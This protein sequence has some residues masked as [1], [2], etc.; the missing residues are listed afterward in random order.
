[1]GSIVTLTLL[2][3]SFTACSLV[4][5]AKSRYKIRLRAVIAQQKAMAVTL[6]A[7]KARLEATETRLEATEDKLEATMAKLQ[8]T[9]ADVS[10]RFKSG[11]SF[12]RWG[13]ESCPNN[14]NLVYTGVAGGKP[15]GQ[16]GSGT[17]PLCLTTTPQ[18]D[19]TKT[20]SNHGYVYGAKY[21]SIPGHSNHEVAPCSVCLAA[22]S[23]TIMVPATLACPSGW[24][25]QYTGHLVS[26]HK[27]HYATEYV[28][29]DGSSEVFSTNITNT[30]L[31]FYYVINMCGNLPCPPFIENRVLTCVVCSK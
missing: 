10:T 22:Q 19:D 27:T 5:C 18:Y 24:T 13:R 1:M 14:T 8:T 2:L 28:C 25:P 30:G 3:L 26:G 7:T 16:K 6:E 15:H 31:L 9:R 23:T 17:N 4:H 20:P 12:I 11:S 29:L 21:N